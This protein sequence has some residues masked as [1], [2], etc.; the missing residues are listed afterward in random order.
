MLAIT[1][2]PNEV[3]HTNMAA[4]TAHTPSND[5]QWCIYPVDMLAALYTPLPHERNMFVRPSPIDIDIEMYHPDVANAHKLYL[6]KQL[7]SHRWRLALPSTQ[8]AVGWQ[9]GTMRHSY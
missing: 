1:I 6:I 8:P 5:I 3:N 9:Q 7:T 2:P 4:Y